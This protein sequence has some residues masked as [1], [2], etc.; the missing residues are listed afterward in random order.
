MII[1]SFNTFQYFY[2]HNAVCLLE[3]SLFMIILAD[4]IWA[5]GLDFKFL[6]SILKYVM[7]TGIIWYLFPFCGLVLD[8]NLMW[9]LLDRK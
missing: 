9:L 5:I 8:E 4:I 3:V 7:I 1:C 6:T 2:V